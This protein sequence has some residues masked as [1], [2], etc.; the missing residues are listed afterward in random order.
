MLERIRREGF[1]GLE[2]RIQTIVPIPN[3]PVLLGLKKGWR[4]DS[5]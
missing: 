5:S 1:D 4:R 2:F 3:L